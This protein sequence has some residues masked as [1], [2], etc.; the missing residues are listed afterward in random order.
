MPYGKIF[1]DYYMKKS[2]R[3]VRLF[4]AHKKYVTVTA[5]SVETKF[6]QSLD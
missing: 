4:Q 2:N 5:H 1:I 3:T 6:H